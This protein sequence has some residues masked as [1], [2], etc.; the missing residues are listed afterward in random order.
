MNGGEV[1]V[2]VMLSRDVDTVFF[3]P[4]G[5]NTTIL[6]AL[7]RNR[8]KVR[9]IPTRLESSAAFACET[10]SKFAKK[11]FFMGRG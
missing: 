10:Y 4:G 6:E 9:A 5:T 3:V 7:S 1:V 11:R 8:N 2:D